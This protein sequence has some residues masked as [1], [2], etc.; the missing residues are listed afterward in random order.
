[1]LEP[2]ADEDNQMED[3]IPQS[4]SKVQKMTA[5]SFGVKYKS[6][7]E[8][9]NFLTVSVHA[10]LPAFQTITIYYLKDLICGR[11]KCKF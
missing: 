10:Y 2:I 7:R 4:K 8:I 6:K 11:K 3:Q 5:A 1:M 9:Y